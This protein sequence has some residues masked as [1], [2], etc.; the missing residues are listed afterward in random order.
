[1]YYAYVMPQIHYLLRQNMPKHAKTA[2]VAKMAW[3]PN[4][5]PVSVNIAMDQNC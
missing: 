5:G 4:K 1:M 3:K 2:Q